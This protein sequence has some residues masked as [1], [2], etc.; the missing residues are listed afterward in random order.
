MRHED[1]SDRKSLKHH[2]LDID[3]GRSLITPAPLFTSFVLLT[4]Y[5]VQFLEARHVD[6]HRGM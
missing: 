6:T 3:K 2:L 4:L 1:V 5:L